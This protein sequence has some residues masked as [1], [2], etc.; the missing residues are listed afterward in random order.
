ML[1]TLWMIPR[2]QPDLKEN[3]TFLSLVV[4][5]LANVLLLVALLC[6]AEDAP[7]QSAKDFGMDWLRNAII[8]G[9]IALRWL[10]DLGEQF[11]GRVH[12]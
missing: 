10:G 6:A 12:L 1:W 5:Y 11:R 2:D 3:G 4:I 8:S 9:D 7:I